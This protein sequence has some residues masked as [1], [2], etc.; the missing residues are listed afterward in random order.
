VNLLDSQKKK[1]PTLPKILSPSLTHK[2]NI[3][4]PLLVELT[5]KHVELSKKSSASTLRLVLV[6]DTHNRHNQIPLPANADIFIHAGDFT[7]KGTQSEIDNFW[8]STV[9]FFL[10][11]TEN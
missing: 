11:L 2:S 6:S 4:K 3:P 1:G 5:P 8:Y 7:K 10:E 9:F